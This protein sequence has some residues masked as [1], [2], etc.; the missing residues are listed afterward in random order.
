MRFA[1]SSSI[2][3]RR[4]HGSTPSLEQPR[5]RPHG[6]RDDDVLRPRSARRLDS[7]SPCTARFSTTTRATVAG[8]TISPPR[9]R[10][11][12]PSAVPQLRPAAE[13]PERVAGRPPQLVVELAHVEVLACRVLPRPRRDLLQHRDRLPDEEDALVAWCAGPSTRAATR[14]P[15][16]RAPRTGSRRAPRCSASGP[17]WPRRRSC[18]WI[19]FQ[20]LPVPERHRVAALAVGQLDAEQ[21]ADAGQA[22]ARVLD[23]VRARARSRDRG[24]ASDATCR[25]ASVRARRR[26]PACRVGE[27]RRRDEPG[28]PGADDGDVDLHSPGSAADGSDAT[29]RATVASRSASSSSKTLPSG[30][31]Q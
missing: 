9:P 1:R 13:R 3:A 24:S 21:P 28:R 15:S 8:W 26:R 27:E 17:A 10:I 2:R 11:A 7:T 19:G 23:E 30:S 31:S 20:P 6:R 16:G 18:S 12:S 5:E 4:S 25:R 14:G 29:M 22:V